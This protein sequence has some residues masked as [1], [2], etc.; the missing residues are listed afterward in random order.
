MTSAFAQHKLV[1]K[2]SKQHRFDCLASKLHSCRVAHLNW[3]VIPYWSIHQTLTLA[4]LSY[5][6]F[7]H[8]FHGKTTVS[9]LHN[10]EL[11]LNKQ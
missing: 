5:Q 8:I 6:Y 4:R 10:A 9:V 3:P 1:Q 11:L 2:P 7:A